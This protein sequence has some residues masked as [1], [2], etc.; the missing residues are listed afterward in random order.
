MKFTKETIRE[1]HKSKINE[2]LEQHPR[3]EAAEAITDYLMFF[4][5]RI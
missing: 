3:Q 2:I 5:N 1:H 4:E